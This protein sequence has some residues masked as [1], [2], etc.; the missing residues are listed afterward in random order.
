MDILE[1]KV[2]FITQY[3]I[4]NKNIM[5]MHDFSIDY[6]NKYYTECPVWNTKKLIHGSPSPFRQIL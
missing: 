4:N 3:N 5:F 6:T 1:K 2:A